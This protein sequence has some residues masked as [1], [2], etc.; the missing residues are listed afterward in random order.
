MNTGRRPGSR[1][2]GDWDWTG[3]F[4]HSLVPGHSLGREGVVRKNTATGGGQ[5]PCCV[6]VVCCGY[7]SSLPVGHHLRIRGLGE[8]KDVHVC[9][10]LPPCLYY[11]MYEVSRLPD[12]GVA[13]CCVSNGSPHGSVPLKADTASLDCGDAWMTNVLIPVYECAVCSSQR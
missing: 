1:E 7:E 3:G 11:A 13:A 12:T 8:E 2:V 5:V 6:V 9:V 10:Q 4:R